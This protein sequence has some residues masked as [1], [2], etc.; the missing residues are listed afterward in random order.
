MAN[1]DGWKQ[2]QSDGDEISVYPLFSDIV[3]SRYA[4]DRKRHTTTL[5]AYR[6]TG[7][8]VSNTAGILGIHVQHQN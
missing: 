5:D 3:R 4:H 1:N 6:N 7:V 8:T 2:M